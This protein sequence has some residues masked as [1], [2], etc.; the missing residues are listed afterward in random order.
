MWGEVH[1]GFLKCSF[2][3][4]IASMQDKCDDLYS[5]CFLMFMLWFIIV[6]C[7][8]EYT[9]PYVYMCVYVSTYLT[10]SLKWISLDDDENCK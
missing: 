6:K 8:Y 2:K 4:K 3:Q 9:T 1:R 5:K 10:K 7:V